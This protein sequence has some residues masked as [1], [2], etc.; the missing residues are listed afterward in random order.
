MQPASAVEAKGEGGERSHYDLISLSD[1]DSDD[2]W[3]SEREDPA[4]L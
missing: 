2:E 3:I 4:S 1:M